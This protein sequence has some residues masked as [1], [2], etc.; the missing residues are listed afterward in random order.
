MVVKK[1]AIRRKDGVVQR[2]TVKSDSG[3]PV[4]RRAPVKN[5]LVRNN[6][7]MNVF[8]RDEGYSYPVSVQRQLLSDNR[9]FQHYDKGVKIGD[10]KDVLNLMKSFSTLDREYV[11]VLGLNNRNMV[12]FKEI[13]SMGTLNSSLIHPREIFKKAI[14]H[15]CNSIIMVH[16]HPS[17]YLSPS[18]EDNQ[19]T[20]ILKQSGEILNIKLLDHIIIAGDKY[21]SY[22]NEGDL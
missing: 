7:W 3:R 12:V 17:G 13:V 10:A 9:L 21:Y 2:Y 11:V 18:A 16:N 5:A 15:S 20:R 4:V 8:S 22:R 14:V 6:D 19:I 1:V